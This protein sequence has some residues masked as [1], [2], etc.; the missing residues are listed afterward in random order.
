ME[1]I[2]LSA[3]IAAVCSAGIDTTNKFLLA[4]L[5]MPLKYYLP[6]IFG[7]LVIISGLVLFFI[8][9]PIGAGAFSFHYI[10]LFL[11]MIAAA[12]SWNILISE[13]L[14][15]E[16]L[17]EYEL[18]ILMTPLI[19][20]ILATVFLPAERNIHIFLAGIVS[21]LA[22]IGAKMKRHHLVLSKS[23]KRTLL[24]VFFIA[25]ESVLLRQLLVVFTPP[26]LYFIRVIVV[27]IVFFWMFK[28]DT[29]VLK[30]RQAVTGLIIAALFGAGLMILKYYAFIKIGVSK[31]TIILLLGPVLT[32]LSS[33]FYFHERKDF[34]KDLIAAGIIVGCII[35]SL[36]VK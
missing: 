28:P 7:F 14:Q 17:H 36:A 9:S 19:T 4:K 30:H 29:N 1:G 11:V 25:L 13:S 35:Y 2:L 20:I 27:A 33:Y 15:T 6:Y 12:V 3:F 16:P 5:K 8:K 26:V 34:R 32:Y 18:I 24:A 22:L 31:T 10:F 23:A 21:S